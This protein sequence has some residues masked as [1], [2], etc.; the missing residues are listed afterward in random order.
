MTDTVDPYS[1]VARTGYPLQLALEERVRGNK[2]SKWRVLAHEHPVGDKG[3]EPL[4]FVDLV[5]GRSRGTDWEQTLYLSRLVVECKKSRGVLMFLAPR[6]RGIRVPYPRLWSATLSPDTDPGTGKR[7]A[8]RR[9]FRHYSFGLDDVPVSEYCAPAIDGKPDTRTIERLASAL[10]G[11]TIRLCEM[12]P[13]KT[14]SS[15]LSVVQVYVP[16]IVTTAELKV[17]VF[18]PASVSLDTGESATPPESEVNDADVV[19][20]SKNLGF[21]QPDL[22]NASA[23][24]GQPTQD[25]F[26]VRARAFESLLDRIGAFESCRDDEWIT[27]KAT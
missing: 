9:E 23:T 4:R 26:V 25:V 27:P 7:L 17:F 2:S 21:D 20:F 6:L 18:D 5:L 8:D 16:I 13:V 22:E 10:V 12:E 1:I 14:S 3:G 15:L 24:R 11:D 19:R